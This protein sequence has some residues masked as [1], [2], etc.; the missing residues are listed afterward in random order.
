MQSADESSCNSTW[1]EKEEE[2]EE[3]AEEEEEDG[4]AGPP[5]LLVCPASDQLG[6][7]Q[8][9][10]YREGTVSRAPASYQGLTCRGCVRSGGHGVQLRLLASRFLS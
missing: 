8:W 2:E 4:R 3:A 10:R 6:R 1:E 7:H 5:L 9:A